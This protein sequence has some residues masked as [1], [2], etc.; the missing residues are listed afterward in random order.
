MP[1]DWEQIAES[2]Y[3]LSGLRLLETRKHFSRHHFLESDQGKQML[4][5]S[6]HQ[7]ERMAKKYQFHLMETLKA[8]GY[9]LVTLPLPTKDEEYCY[10]DQNCWWTLRR[11][12][13]SDANPPWRS[14]TL[15]EKA[16]CSLAALH[17]S[18]RR[19]ENDLRAESGRKDLGWYYL[20]S[21]RW[22]DESEKIAGCF[23]WQ[24]LRQE[25][26][27][28]VREQL[29]YVQNKAACVKAECEAGG[30]LAVTHQDYRPANLRV[31]K[32][33]IAE[34]WD[35]DMAVI[36]F[37]L[38]DVAFASLQYGGRECLFPSLSLKKASLFI[39]AYTAETDKPQLFDQPDLFKWFLVV[40]VL[41]RLLLNYHIEDR[42]RLLR[43]IVSWDWQAPTTHR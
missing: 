23:H 31:W 11:C 39:Q 41:R 2:V 5:C 8:N 42:V 1:D 18:G 43:M 38:Y 33:E 20:P 25:D 6:R 16:A 32:G 3:G 28:F 40:A 29:S 12:A 36:N 19:F 34:I 27:R 35:F 13:P 30:A 14:S 10:L 22:P 4:T 15:I 37:S 26:A 21:T 7:P 9:P 24:V 17:R